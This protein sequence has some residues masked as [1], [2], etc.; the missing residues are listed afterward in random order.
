MTRQLLFVQGGGTGAHDADAPLAASLEAALGDRFALHYP[1]M[2][3]EANPQL[4]AWARHI[5][6]E[7]AQLQAPLTLVGHS[8][9]GTSLLRGL[10]EGWI[11]AEVDGL[12]LLAAPARDGGDWDF[13]DLA[14]PADLARRLAAI[15]HVALYQCRD[16]EVVPFAHL[17]LHAKQ[18]PRAVVRARAHGGHQ[19]GEDL[20]FLAHDILRD[21]TG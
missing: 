12:Y 4:A 13:E 10:A 11:D 18:L 19:F 20:R 6:A 1:C 14:L 15:A 5:A 2:P 9:G 17:A 21:D 7:C 16:D 8:L 3:D